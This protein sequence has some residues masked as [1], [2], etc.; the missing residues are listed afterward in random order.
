M[1]RTG[2]TPEVNA[3]SS[4]L[5]GASIVLVVLSYWIGNRETGSSSR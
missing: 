1:I 3:V 2:I 4:L 5:L